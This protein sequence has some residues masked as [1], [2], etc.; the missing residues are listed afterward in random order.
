MRTTTHRAPSGL[1]RTGAKFWRDLVTEFE[2]DS[3][4]LAILRAAARTVERLERLAEAE[5]QIGE[6]LIVHGKTGPMI[7]PVLVE[8]RMQG[9]A[10][11]RLIASLRIPQ[12]DEGAGS[13]N[14]VGRGAHRQPRALRTVGGV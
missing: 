14:G 6:D 10:L 12:S 3:H 11:A 13:G 4:E 1:G 8:Q 5:A 2:F 7:D 9:Q